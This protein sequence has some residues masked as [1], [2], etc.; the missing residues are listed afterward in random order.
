MILTKA[1]REIRTINQSEVDKQ[2]EKTLQF[3]NNGCC[4][5]TQETIP[6]AKNCYTDE[7][8]SLPVRLATLAIRKWVPADN[9]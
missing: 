6:R 2:K 4:L 3:V 9:L 1:E 7:Q 5:H 8:L